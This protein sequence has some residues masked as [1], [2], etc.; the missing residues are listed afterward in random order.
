MFK[1]VPVSKK[2]LAFIKKYW[3]AIYENILEWRE[4]ED[5][6]LSKKSL[7]SDYIVTQGTMLNAFGRLGNYFF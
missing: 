5:G 6:L 2:N 7:R 4:L 1:N 3:Q